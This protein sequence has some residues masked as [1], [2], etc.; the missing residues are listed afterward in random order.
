MSFTVISVTIPSVP[1][2][3]TKRLAKSYA[4]TFFT[5]F[6]P[7]RTLSPFARTTSMPIT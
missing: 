6:P 5:V 7:K 2:D 3:P 1:S 4:V